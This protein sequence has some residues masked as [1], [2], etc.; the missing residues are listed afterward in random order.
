ISDYSRSTNFIRTK[1]SA[2]L[3]QPAI[4]Y[5]LTTQ[6]CQID[7]YL[8]DLDSIDNNTRLKVLM[9]P[10]SNEETFQT[11]YHSINEDYSIH[12]D[13][14]CQNSNINET[15]VLYVC[16]SNT[17]GDGPLSFARYFHIQSPAPLNISVNSMNVSVLSP[18]EI[19]VQWNI[20]QILSSIN[21]RI[22]WVAAN[23]TDKEKSLIASYNESMVILDNLI[24]FT[25]YKIMI[26]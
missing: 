23:E 12:L 2:P 1:E 20:S 11:S 21:Y 26:N 17:V 6:P 22:R 14:L 15:H 9:K 19:L 7:I 16:L 4:D 13:N 3:V 24:P 25:T 5:I 8:K 10:M 18:R